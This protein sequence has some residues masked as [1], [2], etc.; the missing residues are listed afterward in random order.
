MDVC[1]ITV[2]CKKNRS[3]PGRAHDVT[4][5]SRDEKNVLLHSDALN[6]IKGTMTSETCVARVTDLR[7]WGEEW[8]LPAPPDLQADI[9]SDCTPALAAKL[10]RAVWNKE[11]GR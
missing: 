1:Y 10:K 6:K 7:P 8:V 4:H 3:C 9:R 5:Y 2:G 11:V